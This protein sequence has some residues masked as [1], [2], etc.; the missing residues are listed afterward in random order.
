MRPLY[1]PA[2]EDVTVQG[3]LHALADPVRVRILM[4]L[5]TSDSTNNC[6]SFTNI[7][8]IP[9][10]KSTLSQHFTVLREAGLISSERK[11]VELRN[12]I[13][14]NDVMAKFG[15]L[16]GAILEAYKLEM[17]AKEAVTSPSE[18]Q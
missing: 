13:R 5:I 1:H 15:H 17:Q 6:T 9:L 8:R 18:S 11:G 16:V 7:Y 2:V 3:I 10:P 12:Q 14:T 4:E